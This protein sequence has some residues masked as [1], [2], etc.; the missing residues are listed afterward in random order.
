MTDVTVDIDDIQVR[1]AIDGLRRSAMEMAPAM[2]K[3]AQTLATVTEGNF[4]AQ[5][6]PHWKALSDVTIH[7][8]IGGNK[9]YK[10]DGKLKASAE[11]KKGSLLILQDRGALASSVTTDYDANQAMIGSNLVYAAIHQLGGNAGRGQKVEI[12]ARPYLPADKDGNLQP[13]A[14]VEVLATV[15][16]HLESGAG[17]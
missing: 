4:A 12:S 8:R 9:A 10:K 2:R 13:E 5:G 17:I 11:R 3:I 7:L 15:L 14:K 1:H 6:R 16:R